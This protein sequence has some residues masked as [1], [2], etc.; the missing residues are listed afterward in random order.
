MLL[1][2][3][4]DASEFFHARREDVEHRRGNGNFSRTS[5]SVKAGSLVPRMR[6]AKRNSSVPDAEDAVQCAIAT[7]KLT[8][9]RIQVSLNGKCSC[10]VLEILIETA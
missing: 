10:G 7:L 2:A 9:P 3:D 6:V 5:R 8:C 1:D 4:G